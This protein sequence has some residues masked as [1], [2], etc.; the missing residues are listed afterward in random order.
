MPLVVIMFLNVF[1]PDYLE[2]LYVTVSGRLIMTCALAG[3]A[4]AH[5]MT[6]KMT[7]IEV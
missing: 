6:A 7:D 1:S 2:P 3:L 4:A 5:W